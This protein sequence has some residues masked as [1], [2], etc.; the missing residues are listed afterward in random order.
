MSSLVDRLWYG[1][2][3]PLRWLAPLAWL[4][5]AV[6]ESRRRKAWDRRNASL[7]VPVVV[8]GNITVGG[9]G[10]SPLTARLVRE[11]RVAGWQPV[12]LSRGY[13]GK[14][15]HYPLAVD[16]DTDPSLAGDEPVM[17]AQATGVPVVVDPQRLRGAEFALSRSLGDVLI[18]DDGLQHYALPRDI[19]LAVFDGARGIGN[20]ALIPV[21]PLREPVSRLSG[22]DFVLVNGAAVTDG[23][24]R[25]ENFAGVEHPELF[26]MRLVPSALINLA[27]SDELSP[28]ALSG[29]E[30]R[31]VAGIGNPHRFF[32]TLRALGA[33]VREAPFPDHHDFKPGDLSAGP[34]EWLVMTAKDAVKCRQFASEQAWYLL[35][36]ADLPE[37]FLQSF[38]ERLRECAEQLMD[39]NPMRVDHG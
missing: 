4:Y 20:G 36:E 25:L 12:I 38:L 23:E 2:G 5:R 18:C 34:D 35:V 11:M 16:A 10:K 7:P 1:E 22:V 6:A 26:A 13:G 15:D 30:V 8:V 32:E 19:E 39:S 37:A 14:S 31:A 29:K 24:E 27:T 21:G 3:R 17:L 9:T 33:A 28:G